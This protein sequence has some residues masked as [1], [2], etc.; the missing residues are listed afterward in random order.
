M[1]D[2]VKND[3]ALL[4]SL[5]EEQ[6]YRAETLAVKLS[7]AEQNVRKCKEQITDLNLQIDNLHLMNAF[8]ADTDT[9]GSRQR[10]DKLLRE[11]DKC[12]ELLEK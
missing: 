4:V 5:Y 3:I 10:I 1:L 6:R 2:D 11:I 12:I 7:E 8:M 9:G